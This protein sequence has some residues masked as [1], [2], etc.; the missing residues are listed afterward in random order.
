MKFHSFIASIILIIACTC[1]MLTVDI[2]PE[3]KS[4]VLNF[5]YRV[6]FKYEG[7]M[8][9]SFDRFY[10]VTKFEI[11]KIKDLKSTTFTFDLECEHLNNP[12]I[13]IHWYLKHWSE[14]SPICKILSETNRIL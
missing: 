3:L 8:Y 1:K 5:G 12:K 10:V 4:N 6:N 7:M 13:Y 2:K 11:P 14:N 9:H